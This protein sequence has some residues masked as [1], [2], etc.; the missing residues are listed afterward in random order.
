MSV[1]T[2]TWKTYRNVKYGFKFSYPPDHTP[3]VSVDAADN[4]LV[5]AATSSDS[6]SIA[7]N[8]SDALA[9]RGAVLMVVPVMV[10]ERIGAWIDDNLANYV[11]D[12]KAVSRKN[13]TVAGKTAVEVAVPQS[14]AQSAKIYKL[15]VVQPG[16]YFLVITETAPSA[17]FDLVFSTISFNPR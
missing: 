9:G 11:P 16:N 8:E 1:D 7:D 3:Y 6:V 17:L 13:M 10:D 4:K 5:P 14:A 15:Y 2:S 12:P